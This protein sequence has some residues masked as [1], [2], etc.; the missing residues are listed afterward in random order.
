MQIDKVNVVTSAYARTGLENYIKSSDILYLDPNK[1]RT[2]NWFQARRLQLPVGETE[3]GSVNKVAL[4]DEKV[5]EVYSPQ[6]DRKF[7]TSMELA[8]EQAKQSGCNW[9]KRSGGSRSLKNPMI[10][11]PLAYASGRAMIVLNKSP[12][13]SR[14]KLPF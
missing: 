1:E 10:T 4:L 9:L 2:A 13:T 8:F 7:K 6:D 3:G 11:P 5:K 12:S 14:L